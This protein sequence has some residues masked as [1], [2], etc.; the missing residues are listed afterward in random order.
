MNAMTDHDRL[1]L[2]RKAI[3]R[4]GLALNLNCC[5]EI[6]QLFQHLQDIIQ[7]YLLEFAGTPVQ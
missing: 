7:R 2:V 3:I 5:L 6:T 1:A 4:Y